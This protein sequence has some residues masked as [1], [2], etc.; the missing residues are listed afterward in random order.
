LKGNDFSAWHKIESSEEMLH[1]YKGSPVKIHVIDKQSN[2]RTHLLGDPINHLGA[3]FQVTI[4]AGEWFCAEVA[5]KSSYCLAGCTV[6]PGFNFNNFVLG[7]RVDLL[8][9]FPQHA[10]I[11]T[12]FTRT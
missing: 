1:F 8:N 10:S 5:D 6:T 3:S 4:P 7:N 11:I 2:I 12:K 9:K